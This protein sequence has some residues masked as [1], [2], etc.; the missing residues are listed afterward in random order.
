MARVQPSAQVQGAVLPAI[1]FPMKSLLL[2]DSFSRSIAAEGRRIAG[3]RQ[4]LQ[5]GRDNIRR[6]TFLLHCN[7]TAVVGRGSLNEIG[8][9]ARGSPVRQMGVPGDGVPTHRPVTPCA[10]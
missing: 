10:Y 9:C 8:L 4:W 6:M 5:E 2:F 3:A 1:T 7:V